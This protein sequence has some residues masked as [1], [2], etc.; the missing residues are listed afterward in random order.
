MLGSIILIHDL[1]FAARREAT[2]RWFSLIA[3][4][5]LANQ[6]LFGAPGNIPAVTGATGPRVLG[7]ISF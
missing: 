5:V 6:T 3:F 1:S 4:A 2:M 7:K